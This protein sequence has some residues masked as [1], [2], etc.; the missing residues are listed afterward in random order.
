MS[1]HEQFA[2]VAQR[3]W[4][5]VS[6]SL[7]LLSKNEWMSE[8]L[9]FFSESLICSFLGK[10]KQFGKTDER[11]PSPAKNKRIARK[12]DERS[13]NPANYGNKFTASPDKESRS[14]SKALLALCHATIFD[15][16]IIDAITRTMVRVPSSDNKL[17]QFAFILTWFYFTFWLSFSFEGNDFECR[18]YFW[19]KFNKYSLSG[20]V[21]EGN[22][23]NVIILWFFVKQCPWQ[24]QWS[25]SSTHYWC[26]KGRG[27]KRG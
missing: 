9:I 20:G 8:S 22:V 1:N 3:K 10:N 11:I 26:F 13:P 27:M 12:T 6:K 17:I 19:G 21:L 15:L 7:K 23:I 25:T 14:N 24:K 2:Q 5:I 16:R 4:A 18:L